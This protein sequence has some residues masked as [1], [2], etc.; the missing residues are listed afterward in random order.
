[1]LESFGLFQL[2]DEPALITANSCT[3]LD[4]VITNNTD[5]VKSCYVD[6]DHSISYHGIVFVELCLPAV[7]V[8]KIIKYRDF[9][10]F[11][12]D[13][14]SQHLGNI[15]WDCIYTIPNIEDK[16]EALAVDLL[17][18]YNLHIPLNS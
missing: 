8:N 3:L 10:S 6:L 2:V 18:L 17:D 9:S 14:F 4:H 13:I 1:M 15:S 7:N 16:V 5:L 12:I 11:E